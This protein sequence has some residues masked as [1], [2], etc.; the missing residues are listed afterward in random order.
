MAKL[1][2]IT[3]RLGDLLEP[4]LFTDYC[5]NGLQIEGRPEVRRIACGVSLSRRFIEAA[6]DWEADALLVHHGLFW[7]AMPH[8][9]VLR[10]GPLRDRLKLVLASDLSVLAYHL[11]LDAH[12]EVGNN[13]RLAKALGLSDLTA[14]SV[15]FAGNLPKPESRDAFVTRLE[16]ATGQSVEAFPFGPDPIRR[17]GVISGGSGE[18]YPEIVA[19]G[20]D[21]FVNGD[22]QENLVREYE[23]VGINHLFAGHYAT[24]CFGPRALVDW[25]AEHLGVETRFI[26]IPNPI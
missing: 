19:A 13:A 4:D 16:E 21:T 11:P 25:C 5:V 17:V 24:E 3:A 26:D 15:G 22:R 9:M 7:K 14:V 8:P 20:C 18:R 6:L 1:A 10:D 2:Q 12:P 23:E